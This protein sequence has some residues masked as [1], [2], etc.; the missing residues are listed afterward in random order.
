MVM[1]DPNKAALR[2][3]SVPLSTFEESDEESE[4]DNA[5]DDQND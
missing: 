4:D 2:I 3:Y 1:R 5:D